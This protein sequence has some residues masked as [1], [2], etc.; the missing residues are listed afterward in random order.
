MS[1]SSAESEYN[2]ACTVGMTLAHF[3]M[4]IHELF[5]KGTYV[6]SDEAPMIIL[7]SK[8]VV[9]IYNN[10]K[11]TKHT[12]HIARR[13]HFLRNGEK[14]KMQ[15]IDWCEGGLQLADIGTKNENE[16]YLITRMKYIMV[17]L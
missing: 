12:S 11:D 7:D 13:I 8:S 15:N 1:E 14:C 10:S 16:K 2:A 17:R 6:T 3:I 5:K 4:L 9:C